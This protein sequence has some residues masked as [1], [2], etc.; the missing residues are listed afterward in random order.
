MKS[1]IRTLALALLCAASLR[2]ETDLL[3]GKQSLSAPL[4]PIRVTVPAGEKIVV[5]F[6]VLSGNLWL[7]DNLI[8][9]GANGRSLT[10]ESAQLGDAGT[11]RVMY[12]SIHPIDSQELVL[13]VVPAAGSSAAPAARFLT[14]STRG[15]AGA[16]ALALVSGF[17]I[18]EV[19]G[20]P[21][22]SKKALVRA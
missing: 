12:T 22:V 15:T 18:S 4:P 14:F 1:V 16:G 10:I 9:P 8:V 19:A 2:A 3:L 20:D 7:K 6:P 21:S 13:K 11:Y 5:T 17:V